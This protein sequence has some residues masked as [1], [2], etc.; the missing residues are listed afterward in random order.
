MQ[1]LFAV[2]VLV[3]VALAV[4]YTAADDKDSVHD[5]LE[6]AKANYAT[7]TETANKEFLAAFDSKVQEIAKTGNLDGVKSVSADKKSFETDGKLPNS[8]TMKK[9]TA[10]YQLANEKARKAMMAAYETAVSDY[11]KALQIEKAEAINTEYDTFKNQ[12]GLKLPQRPAIKPP[13]EYQFF[14]W[15]KGEPPVKMISKDE[16]FCYLTVINGAF[17]SGAEGANLEIRDDGYWYLWGTTG[18]SFLRLKAVAVKINSLSPPVAAPDVKAKSSNAMEM[19]GADKV[20][21]LLTSKQW[22]FH[23]EELPP[24]REHPIRYL[25]NGHIEGFNA[26]DWSIVSLIAV[27]QGS[28]YLI[29]VDENNFR[30]FF[31]PTGRQVGIISDPK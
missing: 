20:K 1:K 5:V 30:G 13:F 15:S 26:G 22:F 8:Q 17:G 4:R 18:T 19:P 28:H 3:S 27:K 16:G 7:E 12:A 6:K 11:T 23:W 14:Q 29:P 25:P 9:A 2:F 21:Q 10:D 24:S 31:I